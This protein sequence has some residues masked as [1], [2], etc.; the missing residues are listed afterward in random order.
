MPD[1]TR[2]AAGRQPT[3]APRDHDHVLQHLGRAAHDRRKRRKDPYKDRHLRQRRAASKR[4]HRKRRRDIAAE[5]SPTATPPKRGAETGALTKQSTPTTGKTITSVYNTLGQ[6]TSYTDADENTSTYEYDVDGRVLK[7]NDGKGTQTYT[8]SKTTGLLEELV[9]S[10]HEGMKF[11]ATYDVE[12]NMLTEGYPNGMTAYY[13]YNQTGTPTSLVYKKETHCEEEAKEKCQW[14]KDSIIPSI[15]GQWLTQTSNLSK[16]EYAY[17]AAGRLTQ[18]QN[19]PAGKGCTTR[20]YAYDEDS[21][22]ISLTTREPNL[23]KECT[24]TGGTIESHTYDT[25]DRLTDNSTTYNNFGDITTLPEADTEGGPLTNTYYVDGQA[26]TQT[27]HEQTIGDNLDP[28]GRTRETVA[29]GKK[30]SDIVSH[31][32]GPSND[33][34]MDDEHQRRNDPQHPRHQRP[35]RRD[36]EQLP[37]DR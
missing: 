28:A 21:N 16:Q 29:T 13:T 2:R 37:K 25:A 5:A 18:V 8:Y 26:A 4:H 12:G 9:D 19:T 27:Q 36:P 6:L 14:Y 35:A 10:S 30:T 22:R 15:H 34:V 17:D 3:P 1:R 11:T 31:Y 7:T 24:T 23:K 32:A 20:I 33:A